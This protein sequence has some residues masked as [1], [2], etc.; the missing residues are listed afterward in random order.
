[1]GSIDERLKTWAAVFADSSNVSAKPAARREQQVTKERA[2]VGFDR[3]LA[4]LVP[5][6]NLVLHQCVRGLDRA[7]RRAM[8]ISEFCGRPGCIFR[9]AERCSTE[10]VVLEDGTEICPGDRFGDLHLWN[11][12]IGRML[13]TAVGLGVGA[14]FRSAFLESLQDLA[15]HAS[16]DRHVTE[17]KAFRAQ[18]CWLWR[19]RRNSLEAIIRRCGFTIVSPDPTWIGRVHDAFE[20]LLIYSLVWSFNPNG[21]RHRNFTPLRLQLWISRDELL[22]RHRP[23]E[24]ALE[25][26]AQIVYRVVDPER[27]K[28]VG[29]LDSAAPPDK[30][31]G[32]LSVKEY[33]R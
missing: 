29:A 28:P 11:E 3:A 31:D 8:N 5:V 4:G 14:R 19:S 27:S 9:M 33:H 16:T 1:V 32:L 12:N 25:D 17:M 18:V 21:L 6:C 2:D 15:L 20:N 24:P 7:L 26:A 30:L 22:R 23:T 10:F 13:A